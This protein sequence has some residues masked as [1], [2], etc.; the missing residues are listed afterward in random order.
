MIRRHLGMVA[1]RTGADSGGRYRGAGI[2]AKLTKQTIENL[3]NS[4]RRV[5]APS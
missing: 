5:E 3:E 4:E 2:P 1:D